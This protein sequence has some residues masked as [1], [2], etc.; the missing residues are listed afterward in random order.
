MYWLV[1]VL[2]R[3]TADEVG[4]SLGGSEMCKGDRGR[5]GAELGPNWCRVGAE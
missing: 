3:E 1:C 2:K 4:V 5:V